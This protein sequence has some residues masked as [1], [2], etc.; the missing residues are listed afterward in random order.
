M[1]YPEAEFI[2]DES[3]K[4]LAVNE[5]SGFPPN[6][7]V[8][9]CVGSFE[10]IAVYFTINDSI[11]QDNLVCRVEGMIVRLKKESPPLDQYDGILVGDFKRGD[12]FTIHN[13]IDGEPVVVTGLDNDVE[14]FVRFFPYSDHNVLSSRPDYICSD[15]TKSVQIMGFHQDFNNLDP[16][17]SITYIS[18]NVNFAPMHSNVDTGTVTDGGWGQ[19]K[20]LQGNLPYIING[21]TGEPYAALD[22][23]N[24]RKY[25]N[26][27]N[28]TIT[29]VGTVWHPVAWLPK[30]FIKEVYAKDGNSRDVYFA[31]GNKSP[32]TSDFTPMGFYNKAG[33]E[34]QGIWLPMFNG[35]YDQTVGPGLYKPSVG[36][37][38]SSLLSNTMANLGSRCVPFGGPIYNLLRDVLYML[39]RSTNVMHHMGYGYAAFDNMADRNLNSQTQQLIPKVSKRFHGNGT[40]STPTSGASLTSDNVNTLFH[41]AFLGTY[42]CGVLDPYYYYNRPNGSEAIRIYASHNYNIINNAAGSIKLSN[43]AATFPLV[44]S[45]LKR[46]S[47]NA[48]H[49]KRMKHL[50]NI[51]GSIPIVVT[52]SDVAPSADTQGLCATIASIKYNNVISGQSEYCT[53]ESYHF[54]VI[55]DYT[56]RGGQANTWFYSYGGAYAMLVLPDP[57]FVPDPNKLPPT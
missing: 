25:L 16:E 10:Q 2:V 57:T 45:D 9:K 37:W 51:H 36:A 32:L 26:G 40:K 15:M 19:W 54:K 53:N 46:I 56:V 24:Y 30:L 17:S 44:C 18:E 55:E 5:P 35:N 39:C 34:M 4:G 14:Y 43:V 12:E 6:R 52:Q 33:I 49:T 1:S 42:A 27:V 47:T 50:G 8:F 7:P 3:L 13:P 48:V 38:S 22:P 21:R 20:W 11:L 23:T 41:S 28:S 29:T 31:D